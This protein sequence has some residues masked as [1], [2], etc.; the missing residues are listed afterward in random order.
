MENSLEIQE[1]RL[2]LRCKI[3]NDFVMNM[4]V[5]SKDQ[6]RL[7]TEIAV[8]A[9]NG[10]VDKNGIPYICHPIAVANKCHTSTAACIAMLH[11]VLEDTKVTATDLLAMGVD[12]YIVKCVE[13]LTHRKDTP[14]LDYIQ[15]II[16]TGVY[17]VISVKYADLCDN[18]DPTRGGLNERKM[19]LYLKAKRMLEEALCLV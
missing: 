5:K 15:G 18:V 6:F 8:Q 10:Q 13:K 1:Q 16:D 11:D 9:H 17:N 2:Y 19:P 7:A 4:I 12:P 14:Y 3:K